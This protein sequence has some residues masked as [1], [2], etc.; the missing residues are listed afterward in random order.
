[1]LTDQLEQLR[2]DRRPDRAAGGRLGL[3]EPGAHEVAAA[4]RGAHPADGRVRDVVSVGLAH[5]LDRHAD[6][7]VERL[8]HPRVH[9]AAFA[10]HAGQEAPDL[11]EGALG[12][13][14]PDPLEG[15]LGQLL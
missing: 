5:V 4:R 2:I 11:L 10:T 1:V 14:Q 8:A 13:R 12:R 15:A 6:L 9:D 7:E 3:A